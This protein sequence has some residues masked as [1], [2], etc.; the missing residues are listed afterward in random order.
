MARAEATSTT[1][2]KPAG[3]AEDPRRSHRVLLRVRTNVHLALKGKV[4][5]LPGVTL[6]VHDRGAVIVLQRS[7]PVDARLVLENSATNEKIACK[8]ARP[9]RETPEGYHTVIEFDAPSRDFWKIAFP[10]S[11]WRPDEV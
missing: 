10:P 8:I 5:T 9:A 1:L 4:T 6:S 2:L 7:L 3:A 11:D